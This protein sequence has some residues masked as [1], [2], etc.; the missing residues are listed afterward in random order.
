MITLYFNGD[1]VF[2]IVPADIG[3]KLFTHWFNGRPLNLP[4]D[5]TEIWFCEEGVAS[6]R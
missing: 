4:E 6:Y 5:V 1:D 3:K 2:A